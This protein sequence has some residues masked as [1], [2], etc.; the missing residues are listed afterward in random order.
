MATVKIEPS[1]D[2]VLVLLDLDEDVCPIVDLSDASHFPYKAKP[3]NPVFVFVD[4]DRTPHSSLYIKL[5][6]HG[7]SS[8]RPPLHPHSSSS[9][10]N[11]VDALKM[12]KSKRRSK[13]DLTTIDFDTID[14]CEIKYLL[15]SFDGDVIFIL[16]PINVDISST[17]MRSMDG[18]NKMCDGHPWCTTKTTNIQNDFGLSFRRSS[19][20]GHLQ[21]TNTNCDYLYRNGG[22]HNC[23]AW[24][25]STS[26]PF[27]V[28]DVAPEKLRLECKVCR[29]TPVCIALCHARI[30]YVHSTYPKM[31]RGCIHLGVHE[32]P[33]SNG[34][35]RES[36]D[37]AYQYVATE[38]MKTLTAKNSAIVMATSRTYLTDYLL[39]S[40]SNGEGHN[41]AGS[42]LEAVLDKFSV[43]VTP[44]CRNF[45]SGSRRFIRSGMGTMDSI[46]ALKDHSCYVHGS[47]FPGQSNDKVF[48]FKMSLD[49]PGSGVDFVKRM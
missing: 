33:V 30:L 41:L 15:P 49:R 11:I 47:R 5:V 2:D 17:Y 35:C 29:S 40:P 39:K 1:E 3:S 25:G 44:N 34:T 18:M 36:L 31:S 22:V 21:C 27:S 6:C 4:V 37:M 10:F 16:S 19:C 23:T 45:E 13:Y 9:C 12:T 28:G 43:L 48:V 14:V 38:V 26:I 42:S 32:N 20:A 7:S 46:M 24:S 8:Q